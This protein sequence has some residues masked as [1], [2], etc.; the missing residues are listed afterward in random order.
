MSPEEQIE[1]QNKIYT[2]KRNAK[3][4]NKD[5]KVK[6]NA[7]PGRFISLKFNNIS[8][9][10]MIVLSRLENRI[11]KPNCRIIDNLN[12]SSHEDLN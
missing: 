8:E 7:S 12:V 2:S 10:F 3:L 5:S 9:A 4:N 11:A 1:M 6:V